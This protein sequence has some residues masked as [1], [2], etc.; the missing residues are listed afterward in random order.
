[1][2]FQNY[3]TEN[4]EFTKI[5]K[6]LRNVNINKLKSKLYDSFQKFIDMIEESDYTDQIIR[7]INKKFDMNVKSTEELRKLTPQKIKPFNE[8]ENLNEDLEHWWKLVKTELFPTLAFYP[9]LTAW[10]E[11]DKI[12]RGAGD[13]N[14]KVVA[15]YGLFWLLLVSGKY[16]TGWKQWKKSNP[17]EYE[18]ERKIGKGGIV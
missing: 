17:D 13:A 15:V 10:L 4:K 11:I 14:W 5:I 16:I 6:D 7:I 2:R 8:S 12:I 18:K 9:A 3:I 1:M